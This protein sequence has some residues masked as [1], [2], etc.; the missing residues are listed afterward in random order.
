[1]ILLTYAQP[2]ALSVIS[3]RRK[4][5]HAPWSLGRLGYP[6]NIAS[7]LFI[8]FGSVAFCFPVATPF[9]VQGMSQSLLLPSPA[10][11]RVT[12]C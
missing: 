4:V 5:A 12:Q 7:L 1:M 11:P 10:R 9:D 6:I 2:I 8:A 3:G